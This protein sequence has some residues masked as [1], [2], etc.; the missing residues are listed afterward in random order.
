[1]FRRLAILA[2]RGSDTF[3]RA[4]LSPAEK[5]WLVQVQSIAPHSLAPK[6]RHNMP[7]WLAEPLL[8][9]LGDEAQESSS[10]SVQS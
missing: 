8:A 2:W 3:L 1:M 4:A 9:R 6:L 5:D 7:D 10:R